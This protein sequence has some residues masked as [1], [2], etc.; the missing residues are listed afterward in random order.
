MRRIISIVTLYIAAL[1]CTS[2]FVA[3]GQSTPDNTIIP[4]PQSIFTQNNNQGIINNE[5]LFVFGPNICTSYG[6]PYSPGTSP[7][8]TQHPHTYNFSIVIPPD[9]SDDVLR[10]ELF[11]PDSFNQFA[12][13]DE[14]SYSDTAIANGFP[15]PPKCNLVLVNTKWTLVSLIQLNTC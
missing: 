7:Y 8:T 4:A 15:S 10:V 13:E 12:V 11:D 14:V 9:Y 5:T 1:L 3:F 2:I 6:D